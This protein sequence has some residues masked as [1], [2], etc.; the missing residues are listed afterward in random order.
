MALVVTI[1]LGASFIPVLQA[2]AES[3]SFATTPQ[4]TPSDQLLPPETARKLFDALALTQAPLKPVAG[5]VAQNDFPAAEHRLAEYFRQRTTPSWTIDPHHPDRN[6]PY[7]R[8]KAD[9]AARGHVAGEN[10]TVYADFPGNRIDWFYNAT[11]HQPGAIPN[12]SWPGMLSRM[13]FWDDLAAAYRSTGD[14]K[15]A[16]AWVQQMRSFVLSCPPPPDPGG[17]ASIPGPNPPLYIPPRDPSHPPT[18]W[19]PIDVGVRLGGAW[20]DAFSSF[21]DSP[22]VSDQ[23]LLL[24]LY[25]YLLEGEWIST[26]HGP[27]NGWMIE[28]TGL[29]TTGALFPEFKQAALWREQAVQGQKNQVIS[30]FLPDG[31]ENELTT[32]YHNTCIDCA[33]QILKVAQLT[34]HADEI[35][36]DY[37]NP[38]EKAYDF[39]AYM[40]APDRQIPLFNDSWH[41]HIQGFMKTAAEIFPQR[42]DYLWLATDGHEG[43]PPAQ[44]SFAFN[45]GGFYAMRSGWEQNANYVA[46]RD[47]PFVFSHGH[48]DKLNVVMWAYGRE[49]LF[50]SGGGPYDWGQWRQ[51]SI[52]TYSKNTVLVDGLD[53][54]CPRNLAT[55]DVPEIDSRWESTSDY[56][57]AAGIYDEA[58]GPNNLHPA[59]HYRRVLFLKPDLAIVADTLTPK[60]QASHTYQ[61][62]WNLLTTHTEVIPGTREVVT[63]DSSEPNL[64]IVPLE[65]EGLEVR[66]A[67][68]QMKPEILGWNVLHNTTTRPDPATSVLQTRRGS[69]VQTFLTLLVP[70]STGISLPVIKG[71]E[72]KSPNS[73]EVTFHDGGKLDV[74]ASADPT[75][76]IEVTETRADG[77][78][79]RHV[80]A[81]NSK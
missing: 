26:H 25:G 16:A 72:E 79:G 44:T 65:T 75:G 36:S 31:V 47:G 38:L 52:D 60:D 56:D 34:G 29:Y 10:T 45:Y 58:Y 77:S 80:V 48:Q 39:D 74:V 27:G 57:F 43:Q 70:I 13:K 37:I 67:S 4:P 18:G 8:Q 14:E 64:D 69:G 23:D 40:M 28:R 71:V 51:Y 42:K 19:T 62:R 9:E 78:P 5:A 54:H 11:F 63:T 7:D 3:P 59:S 17:K 22:S 50:N 53:Q 30:Q 6:T 81:G 33:V 20:P 21:V 15:Y 46:F 12:P 41:M 76:T 2:F 68:G 1:C 55:S 61:A 49:L 32:G 66:T 73:A 35:P 24:F